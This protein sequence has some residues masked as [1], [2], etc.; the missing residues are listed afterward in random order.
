VLVLCGIVGFAVL[1]LL[2]LACIRSRNRDEQSAQEQAAARRIEAP[3]GLIRLKLHEP[4]RKRPADAAGSTGATPRQRFAAGNSSSP[5]RAADASVHSV[6]WT[7][8]DASID[9]VYVRVI[10][11]RHVAHAEP[12]YRRFV[13]PILLHQ[14]GTYE[15]HVFG[16]NAA[17][18]ASRIQVVTFVV[19][20]NLDVAVHPPEGAYEGPLEVTVDPAALSG[21]SVSCAPTFPHISAQ[22]K[23]LLDLTGIHILTLTPKSKATGSEPRTF[24]YNVLP[25]APCIVPGTG[26]ITD[27][28]KIE[29]VPQPAAADRDLN[30]IRYS[31]DGR[32]PTTPYAGPFFP[33]GNQAQPTSARAQLVVKAI[34]VG[35]D[36]THSKVAEANLVVESSGCVVYDESIPAPTCVVTTVNPFL[37][38]DHERFHRGQAATSAT[39]DGGVAIKYK[40]KLRNVAGTGVEQDY[41]MG[42]HVKLVA[43]NVESVTAWAFDPASGHVSAVVTYTNWKREVRDHGP[44]EAAFRRQTQ[45]LLP[46][47]IIVNA[48]NIHLRWDKPSR[49][50]DA[51]TLRW[52]VV[53][54]GRAEDDPTGAVSKGVDEHAP[55][56][57]PDTDV[58]I[59]E[60]VMQAGGR[61][62]IEARFYKHVRPHPGQPLYVDECVFYGDKFARAFEL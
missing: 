4:H 14:P 52:S 7:V 5:R 13:D 41:R 26:A 1:V 20:G 17:N 48:S 27:S 32:Y 33:P 34:A 9:A 25:P 39:S 24:K 43:D 62:E 28:T 23:L 18:A 37:T 42:D 21:F 50:A 51:L 2:V 30:D 54:G 19:S 10:P 12:A 46:P 55:V 45:S 36:G 59:S 8:E 3:D 15:F 61:V 58:D 38:F 31:V 22:G 40:L 35:R 11:P 6:T 56:V 47:S 57:Q 29:L 44:N 60:H 16:T 53:G 49:D